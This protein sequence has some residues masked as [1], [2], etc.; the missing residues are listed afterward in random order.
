MVYVVVSYNGTKIDN[1]KNTET[2][3]EIHHVFTTFKGAQEYIRS[4]ICLQIERD[5][6]R[7]D[8]H[9]YEN[10]VEYHKLTNLDGDDDPD[11]IYHAYVTRTYKEYYVKNDDMFYTVDLKE[12]S[13]GESLIKDSTH[14]EIHR[15]NLI[16]NDNYE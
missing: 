1:K 4:N 6:N 14:F 5:K 15:K 8:I 7:T 10:S 9:D 11:V 12:K 13:T 2:E 16:D 3:I